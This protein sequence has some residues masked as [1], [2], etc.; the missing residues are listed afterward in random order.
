MVNTRLTV[1]NPAAR[2]RLG[3]DIKRIDL[4]QALTEPDPTRRAAPR[5]L[6]KLACTPPAGWGG[7]VSRR[8]ADRGPRLAYTEIFAIP[9]ERTTR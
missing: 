2:A 1:A 9:T 8:R 4:E 6:P 3:V 5:R 7:Y